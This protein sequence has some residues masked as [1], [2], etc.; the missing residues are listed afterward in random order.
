M[1]KK[2]SAVSFCY[3]VYELLLIN[4]HEVSYE[5]KMKDELCIAGHHLWF[6][7]NLA[8][9]YPPPKIPFNI[10]IIGLRQP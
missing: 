4:L 5:N 9:I 2:H 1:S 8:A 6:H 3:N 7:F 10:K